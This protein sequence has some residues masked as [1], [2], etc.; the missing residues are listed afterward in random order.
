MFPLT[1]PARCDSRV[2][3]SPIGSTRPETQTRKVHNRPSVLKNNLPS[4]VWTSKERA[5]FRSFVIAAGQGG[6][7]QRTRTM[8]HLVCVVV[9]QLSDLLHQHNAVS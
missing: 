9:V 8:S 5:V 6:L 2:R 1:Q 4:A 3:L 7:L